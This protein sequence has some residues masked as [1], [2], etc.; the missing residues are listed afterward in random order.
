MHG[1]IVNF[2]W[3]ISLTVQYNSAILFC[4]F[5]STQTLASQQDRSTPLVSTHS[6]QLNI[7]PG[8]CYS[9]H[10]NNVWGINL[11]W[12]KPKTDWIEYEVIWNP[13][14]SLGRVGRS[15]II[16]VT[17]KVK[18]MGHSA[19]QCFLSYILI[20]IS[21]ISPQG[22]YLQ[23]RWNVNRLVNS[24]YNNKEHNSRLIIKRPL[25]SGLTRCVGMHRTSVQYKL[26]ATQ[27]ANKYK[28]VALQAWKTT[29]L[30]TFFFS[31]CLSFF[32]SF[33]FFFFFFEIKLTKLPPHRHRT[34]RNLLPFFLF[35]AQAKRHQAR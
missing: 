14:Y 5:G 22:W 29:C 7:I 23:F 9:W 34:E 24:S 18:W 35:E 19:C 25:L 31:F 2:R 11:T 26:T 13:T 32:V 8:Y 33:W 30:P 3:I 4:L 12:N 10:Y 17:D 21:L 6:F 1:I 15:P 27:A 16:F 20:C 28:L